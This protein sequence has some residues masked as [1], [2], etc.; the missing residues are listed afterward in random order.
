MCLW[1]LSMFRGFRVTRSAICILLK[2][3]EKSDTKKKIEEF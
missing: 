2:E 1:Y 3:L